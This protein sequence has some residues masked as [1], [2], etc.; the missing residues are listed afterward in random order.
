MNSH[1]YFVGM[2]SVASAFALSAASALAQTPE[3]YFKGKTVQINI[4][5]TAGGGIDIGARILARFLGKYLP[6]NPQVIAQNMPGAGGVRVL[7]Y[8]VTQAPKDGTWI[9][10]F[11]S[12]PLLDPV[13][14][15]RK[16]TYGIND[17]VA[18]GA[19][20]SDNGFCTTWHL[21]PVKTLEQ[22]KQRSVT[23][24]GTGA[25]SGTDTE[26]LVINEVLGTKFKVITGYLGTQETALAVERG[27]V[28]GRCGFGFASIKASKPDWLKENKLNF[29]VQ[30]GLTPHP[31]AKD[32]PM[33]LDLAQTPEHKAMVR[34]MA[35]A[36]NLSRPYLG[37]PGM[38]RERAADLRKAF[39][40][41]LGDKELIAEFVKASGG[42]EPQPTSGEAMQKVL[43]SMQST[44]M[45]V[46]DR[47]RTLLNP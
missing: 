42:D 5:G 20:E 35:S 10:A 38:N 7:E 28:D 17:F 11:A 47:L 25:G 23:V 30:I 14:G 43:D 33:A 40:A 13:I 9:G 45:N 22:A 27:E 37:P 41:A 3:G 44:P 29:L 15:P 34:L 4:A 1:R 32:V 31:L 8:L 19:L 46:R 6:G 12:G 18:I 16:P 2:V 21:S 24:A 26:P 36:L 39:M